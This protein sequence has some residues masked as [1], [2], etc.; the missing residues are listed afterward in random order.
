MTIMFLKLTE[1]WE[2][3]ANEWLERTRLVNI[4]QI[5]TVTPPTKEAEKQVTHITMVSGDHFCV[6]ETANQIVD[7][8][9][10]LKNKYFIVHGAGV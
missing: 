8:Y 9:A 3:G 2:A 1:T 5:E 10:G 6:V 7:P 4:S